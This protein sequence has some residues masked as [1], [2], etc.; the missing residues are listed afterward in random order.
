MDTMRQKTI[1]N[2]KI[3][4]PQTG[5]KEGTTLNNELKHYGIL[6]MKW[7][8][9]R[10]QNKDGSLTT[11]G[12][13]RYAQGKDFSKE[14]RADRKEARALQTEAAVLGEAY[15]DSVRGAQSSRAKADKTGKQKHADRAE[16]NE[17][18]RDQLK[19]DYDEAVNKLNEHRSKMTEKYGKEALEDIRYRTNK[20]SGI[21]VVGL[22][23]AERR[24]RGVQ[25]FLLGA[26][27][28]AM[29]S[30]F[31]KSLQME[32]AKRY[33]DA[34]HKVKIKDLED[35]GNAYVSQQSER[36]NSTASQQKSNG[37]WSYTKEERAA[38]K[39]EANEK[40]VWNLEF[41]ERVQNKT[42]AS[43]TSEDPKKKK[44]MMQE[45]DA[46]LKDPV[47]YRPPDGDEE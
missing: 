34:Y 3:P 18:T 33:L 38:A 47:N 17:K 27:F 2:E 4:P 42:Y 43:G 10:Y 16:L 37:D 39:T 46:F 14:L 22:D 44:R 24:S 29:G 11:A 26:G 6:G 31:T 1:K 28:G 32:G 35:K 30:L 41:L 15:A 12:Q 5:T 36:K 20:Q 13:R 9:R 40:D 8:V 25:N 7:G 45:Y 23:N 21:Q 19:A